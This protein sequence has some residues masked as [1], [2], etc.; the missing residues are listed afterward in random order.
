M[1]QKEILEIIKRLLNILN[2]QP[3]HGRKNYRDKVGQYAIDYESASYLLNQTL[4]E[5]KLPTDHYY[6]SVEAQELWK[7][8]TSLPTK[9]ILKHRNGGKFSK[10]YKEN[11]HDE[12]IVTVHDIIEELL[13]QRKT[14]GDLTDK[15]ISDVVEKTYICIMLK[16]ENA[17]LIGNNVRKTRKTLNFQKI[18]NELYKEKG[19]NASRII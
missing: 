13:S 2:N 6:I 1:I 8:A 4:R 12:H 9:D 14:K 3:K 18:I 7:K 15:E 5:I 10:F 19:I 17:K 11:F 16:I